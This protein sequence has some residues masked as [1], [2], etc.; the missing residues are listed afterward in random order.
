MSLL[1]KAK[2][3]LVRKGPKPVWIY[4]VSSARKIWRWSGERKAVKTEAKK[5]ALCPTK[6]DKE[7]E[8]EIDHITPI[9]P[10]PRSVSGDSESFKG[11]DRYF[12]RLF[13][14]REKLQALCHKCHKAKTLK[15][16][17]K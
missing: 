17:K 1:Q 14:T 3:P 5:C 16:R 11:W 7:N 10:A 4:L 2:E 6:F 8:P 13:V 9:G 15:E 12:G